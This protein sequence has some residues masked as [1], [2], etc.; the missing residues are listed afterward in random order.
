MQKRS[1]QSPGVSRNDDSNPSTNHRVE[2]E[3]V[4]SVEPVTTGLNRY[5]DQSRTS[6][7]GIKEAR[8]RRLRID[9][10][11]KKNDD[12]KKRKKKNNYDN[13]VEEEAIVII[14]FIAPVKQVA[15]DQFACSDHGDVDDDSTG[16][17]SVIDAESS[18][19]RSQHDLRG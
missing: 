12:K 18:F 13:D 10:E 17:G 8:F 16:S 15:E 11:L 9:N 14:D 7:D 1:Q 6:T 19:R 2:R 3:H 5:V 4:I